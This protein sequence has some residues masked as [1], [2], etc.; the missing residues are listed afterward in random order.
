ML[1]YAPVWAD[2]VESIR[3]L[4]TQIGFVR[5]ADKI[6]EADEAAR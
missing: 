2:E 4:T 3:V 5:T 1:G 6:P